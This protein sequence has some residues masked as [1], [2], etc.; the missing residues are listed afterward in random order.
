MQPY[1]NDLRERV[2]AA[3][4]HYEGSMRQMSRQ[5][6]STA[7]QLRAGAAQYGSAP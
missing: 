6:R 1:S 4:D 2:A 7:L 3:V 5:F